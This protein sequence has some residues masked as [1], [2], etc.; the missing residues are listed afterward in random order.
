MLL[1]RRAARWLSGLQCRLCQIQCMRADNWA[2]L[3]LGKY[4]NVALR[5]KCLLNSLTLNTSTTAWQCLGNH[6]ENPNT[7]A[8]RF[9][10]SK[11]HSPHYRS[12]V[13]LKSSVCHKGSGYLK[14]LRSTPSRV[15][16]RY[17]P[18]VV[19]MALSSGFCFQA[20]KSYAHHPRGHKFGLHT[21]G[22]CGCPRTLLMT[23]MTSHGQWTAKVYF[24]Q[25]SINP[26]L[27]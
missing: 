1:L 3:T 8:A 6:P 17:T 9:C 26:D 12:K 20:L 22:L 19:S 13:S 2:V 27:F 4:N 11:H 14:F 15:H 24:G 10:T 18:L 23:K 16:F 25:F 21:D 5:K 7:V